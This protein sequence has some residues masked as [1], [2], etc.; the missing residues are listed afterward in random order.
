MPQPYTQISPAF[1][2]V[3]EFV[4]FNDEFEHAYED[5][6]LER[7]IHA[8]DEGQVLCTKLHEMLNLYTTDLVVAET[9][10]ATDLQVE[11]VRAT[12]SVCEHRQLRATIIVAEMIAVRAKRQEQPT[13]PV[14]VRRGGP[15]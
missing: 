4:K 15:T 6:S 14:G 10:L 3:Y 11:L 12:Y 1:G 5:D 2:L 13:Q 9:G 8:V 7:M